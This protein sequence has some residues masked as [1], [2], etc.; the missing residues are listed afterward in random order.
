MAI[1]GP[2][3]GKLRA[4]LRQFAQRALDLLMSCPRSVIRLARAVIP[5]QTIPFRTERR[6]LADGVL[7]HDLAIVIPL[8]VDEAPLNLALGQQ[9]SEGAVFGSRSGKHGEEP[10]L[11]LMDIGHV[12]GGGQLTVRHV[13]E[14]PATG[15]ATEQVPGGA[16]RL[17]VRHVAAGDLEIQRNRPV[18]GNREDIEQLLE[19]GPMVLVVTP[20]NRHACS[21]APLLFLGGISIRAMESDRRGVVV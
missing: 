1:P 7:V 9:V 4:Q 10:A 15:Q 14:V 6:R 21:L 12:L 8:V 2:G 18:P 11:A 13:E 3:G 5:D 20:G 19:V 17:V 16:M